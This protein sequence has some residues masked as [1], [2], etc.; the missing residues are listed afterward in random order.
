VGGSSNVGK[1]TVTVTQ[2]LPVAIT[3]GVGGNNVSLAASSI[4]GANPGTLV[5]PNVSGLAAGVATVCSAANAVGP[6]PTGNNYLITCTAQVSANTAQLTVTVGAAT[7]VGHL[8]A[9][10]RAA[11]LLYGTGLGLPAICLGLCACGFGSTRKASALRRIATRLALL[12]LLSLLVLLPACSG[13]FKAAFGTAHAASYNLT[14]MG[15]VTDNN[16][17]VTG[18]EIF[19]VPVQVVK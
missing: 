4:T 10:S 12:G 8:S 19:T 6:D 18:I 17:N 2:E 14:V 13:G 1:S 16:N 3:A 7:P 9:D 11:K 15:Y 5:L